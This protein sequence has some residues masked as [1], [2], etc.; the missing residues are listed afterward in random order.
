MAFDFVCPF[1]HSRIRVD[2]RFAGKSGP[3]AECG[4][5]VTMPGKRRSEAADESSSSD[6]PVFRNSTGPSKK[7]WP[8]KLLGAFFSLL[9]IGSLV[10]VSFILFFPSAKNAL[11]VRQR[12]L[13]L[14]N[15]KQIADALNSY[16]KTYG[17]YPTPIVVESSGKPLYSWRVL[18]L[19]QLGYASLYNDYQLDQTWD[20]PTNIDLMTRM[21]PVYACPGNLNALAGQVTNFAL[22]IGPGSLFPSGTSVDPDVMLD[23]PS[24]TLLVVETTDGAYNWTQPGDLSTSSGIAIGSRPMVDIGGNYPDCVIAATVDGSPI[25]I[26]KSISRASLDAIITPNGE[27]V[28]ELATICIA[29]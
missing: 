4:K 26:K 10:L 28:V 9:V 29:K 7:V 24:E 27:E 13:G 8:A 19:P 25:A 11:G 3:C 5:P 12:T 1:C 2:D 20:S 16:R 18:I 22:I 15:V 21:P 14:S 17:N 6:G 23:K